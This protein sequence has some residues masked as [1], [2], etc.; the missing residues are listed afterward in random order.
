MIHQ[1]DTDVF[2]QIQ[3]WIFEYKT[4]DDNKM[5]AELKKLITIAAMPFVKRI[6]MGLARRSTDP[7]DDLIQAGSLGL[8]KALE[9]YDAKPESRFKSYATYLIAGEMKHYLRDK[10][11][12]IKPPRDIQELSY[13]INNLLKEI[14]LDG[15]D[16]SAEKIADALCVPVSKVNEVFDVDRRKK[17]LSLDEVVV[18]DDDSYVPLIEKIPASDYKDVLDM[19]E[20]KIMLKDAIEKL[21]DRLKETISMIYYQDMTQKQVA[22]ILNISQMQVSRRLRQA[23]DE[24]HGIITKSKDKEKI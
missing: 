11:S 19:Y 22:D 8:L 20:A 21:D 15:S 14:D 17:I 13:R 1:K 18:K 10:A 9:L 2:N 12:V 24:L 7:V 16:L 4:T 5:K 23:F 6:A 3:E